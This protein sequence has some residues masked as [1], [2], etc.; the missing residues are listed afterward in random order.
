MVAR[1][2]LTAEVDV[3]QRLADIEVRR[4]NPA[5]ADIQPVLRAG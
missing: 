2:L 1:Q 5:T 4:D 3:L